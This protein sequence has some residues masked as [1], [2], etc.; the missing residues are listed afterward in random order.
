MCIYHGLNAKQYTNS[1]LG[2]YIS[3]IFQFMNF[4]TD[5]SRHPKLD[6]VR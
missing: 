4:T 5:K 1:Q 6:Y 3:Y 2:N